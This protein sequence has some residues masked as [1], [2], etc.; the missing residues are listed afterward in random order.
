M[1]PE[2][3]DQHH[4]EGNWQNG[5]RLG[6]IWVL[7][8]VGGSDYTRIPYNSLILYA[9]P[10]FPCSFVFN[11][12]HMQLYSHNSTGGSAHS[13]WETKI[14]GSLHPLERP[15]TRDQLVRDYKSQ[16]ST[17]SD[18]LHFRAPHGIM[19]EASNIPIVGRILR[20]LPM[21]H[22]YV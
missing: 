19:P 18:V 22:T 12:L 7:E 4:F 5:V 3:C 8:C 10:H 16:A 21:A 9:R 13:C 14:P 11:G 15:L 1:S 6:Q 2:K 20:W 17:N